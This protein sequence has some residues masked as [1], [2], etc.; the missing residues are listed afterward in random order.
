MERYAFAVVSELARRGHTVRVLAKAGASGEV[1]PGVEVI[2]ALEGNRRDDRIRMKPHAGGCDVW[3]VMNAAWAWMARET[4]RPCVLSIHG[5]DFIDPNPV[6][7]FD[8]KRRLLLPWGSRLDYWLARRYTPYVMRRGLARVRRILANSRFTAAAFLQRFPSCAGRTSIVL[9]GIDAGLLRVPRPP[10][11]GAPTSLLSVCR[12]SEPRKSIDVV[13]H[14]LARLKPRFAFSYVVV[15]DGPLRVPLQRLAHDLGLDDRVRFVGEVDDS[16]LA[17]YYASAD[18]FI[19][20]SRRTETSVEG[21]GMVYVEAAA[22]GT[23]VLAARSGGT[24]DAVR[25]G[26]TGI[27]I[28][29]VGVEPLADGLGRFLSG[30]VRFESDRCRAFAGAYSWSRTVDGVLA[31]YEAALSD[32]A[33]RS[34]SFRK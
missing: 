20:T 15:G 1:A 8:L 25:E 33:G 29:E 32:I 9:P 19:L 17:E 2:G 13:L 14:A 3:H 7:G 16:H 26:V 34:E 22:C 24:A 11:G 5:N 4:P 12:L 28:E 31:A 10:R 30:E 21:F 6:A 18:L 23:P 27:L